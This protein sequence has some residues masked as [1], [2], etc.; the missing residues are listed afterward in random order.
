[1]TT[2]I[3]FR[4]M[5]LE[6]VPDVMK[7]DLGAFP[8]PWTKEIYEQ[9]LLRNDFAHY[10]VL[11]TEA[12]EIIG[13]VGLWIIFEDAQITNI[14]VHKTYRGISIDERLFLFALVYSFN[15]G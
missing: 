1:M 12:G 9:E 8:S 13:Y 5:E 7:I 14:V 4:K 3:S 2:T 15:I 10:F 6:D 11:E